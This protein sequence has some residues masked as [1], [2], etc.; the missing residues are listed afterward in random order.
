[1]KYLLIPMLL[2]L[3]C[4]PQMSDDY[5]QKTKA[6]ITCYAGDKPVVKIRD[7]ELHWISDGSITFAH[8]GVTRTFTGTCDIIR[9]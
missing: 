7:A 1:M 5:A 6:D 2:L 8:N 3:G 9:Y 4:L